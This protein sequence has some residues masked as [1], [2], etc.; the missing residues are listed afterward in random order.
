MQDE[1][2]FSR[3]PAVLKPDAIMKHMP[4]AEHWLP[5]PA[6]KIGAN[7]QS[8]SISAFSPDS[9]YTHLHIKR[10]SVQIPEA[11]SS[12]NAQILFST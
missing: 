4:T 7:H 8:S 10:A 6:L 12:A 11:V 3:L 9:N 1:K 2:S 5:V